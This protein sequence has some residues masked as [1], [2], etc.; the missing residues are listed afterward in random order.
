VLKDVI[1]GKLTPEYARRQ[2]GVVI[3]VEARKVLL[4]ELARLRAALRRF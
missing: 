1:E 2:Y 4:E 3:D